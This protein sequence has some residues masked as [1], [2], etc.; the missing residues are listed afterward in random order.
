[1]HA[2]GMHRDRE[3]ERERMYHTPA[4]AVVLSG[5]CWHPFTSSSVFRPSKH[6]PI[7]R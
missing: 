1:M 2:Y 7:S 3:R 4:E 5:L 6:N